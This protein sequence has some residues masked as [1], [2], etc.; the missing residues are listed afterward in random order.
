MSFCRSWQHENS[1]ARNT[2]RRL[3]RYN[4]VIYIVAH[5]HR[6]KCLTHGQVLRQKVWGKV[7]EAI[8]P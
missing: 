7:V 2:I 1:G 4:R 5:V 8:N 3:Q 6:F